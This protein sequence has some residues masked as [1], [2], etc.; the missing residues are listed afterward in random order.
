MYTPH[1]V[2]ALLISSGQGGGLSLFPTLYCVH[3]VCVLVVCFVWG[4]CVCEVCV[5]VKLSDGVVQASC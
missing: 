2:L 1:I 4:V 3:D 5:Y